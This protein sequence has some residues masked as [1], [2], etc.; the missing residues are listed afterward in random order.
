MSSRGAG[1]ASEGRPKQ[2]DLWVHGAILVALVIVTY[3][4]VFKAGFVWDDIAITDNISLKTLDGLGKIWFHPSEIQHEGHYWPLV[5]TSFWIEWN[6]WGLNPVPYHIV[7]LLLHAL[8]VIVLWRLYREF[9]IPGAWFAAAIFAVHPVHVDSVAWIIERKDL[10]SGLFYLLAFGCFLK[11]RRLGN[12]RPYALSLLFFTLGMLSKSVTITLPFA[13]LVY[14]WWKQERMSVRDW[15]PL[16]PLAVIGFGIGL[17]DVWRVRSQLSFDY[18]LSLLERVL[19]A[20]R[21]SWFYV[22]KL[23]WPFNMMAFYDKW[24]LDT[25]RLVLWL[26]PLSLLVVLFLLWWARKRLG[27]GCLAACVIYLL[28]LSPTLGF[29]DFTF[30]RFSFVADRFQFLASASLIALVGAGLMR[31]WENLQRP[32]YGLVVAGCLLAVLAGATWAR[33]RT[34]RDDETF[35][36]ANLRSNPRAWHGH[37]CLGNLLFDQG[38]LSEAASHYQKVIE[39]NPAHDFAH[40]N[41]GKTFAGLG[42]T[43]LAIEHYTKAVEIDPDNLSAVSNLGVALAK[44]G[45]YEQASVHLLKVHRLVPQDPGVALNLGNLFLQQKDLE[46]AA[47]YY[48]RALELDPNWSAAASMLAWVLATAKDENLRNGQEALRLA[49]V[50]FQRGNP[51]DP[52]TLDI[53]SA[54]YA[55]AGEYTEAL[56][57]AK[58]ALELCK[59]TGQEEL[60][61]QIASRLENYRAKE[62][63]TQ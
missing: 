54:A 49:K 55:A 33:T 36:T 6:L 30:M 31:L 18:G 57:Y 60:A 34:Y 15:T 39:L 61:S 40:N 44:T 7:N 35:W 22:R 26:F 25:N 23:L 50:A 3:S 24:H 42:E 1:S 19:V 2:V 17:A 51:Q 37:Y 63:Y 12:W 58:R 14:L 13:L 10:F 52:R 43:D 46:N 41:L 20:G 16:V 47:D 32:R 29:V 11:Y 53:L 4:P 5:Y 8:L 28:T 38:R 62:D 45:D 59:A 27:K 21:A 56:L 9:R 48:R